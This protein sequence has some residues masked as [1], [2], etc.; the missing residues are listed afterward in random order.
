MTGPC[1][2]RH[3][4]LFSQSILVCDH[5]ARPRVAW[6]LLS[7]AFTNSHPAP[8][9]ELPHCG[10]RGEHRWFPQSSA[11]LVAAGTVCHVPHKLSPHLTPACQPGTLRASA[12]N[13]N[14]WGFSPQLVTAWQA[15]SE[16][17][18]PHLH[19][20]HSEQTLQSYSSEI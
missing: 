20:G 14:I 9:T 12:S 17:R 19:T 7:L 13:K 11:W 16:H 10:S 4:P 8:D 6:H 1:Q 5:Q 15:F 18:S 3:L 2:E